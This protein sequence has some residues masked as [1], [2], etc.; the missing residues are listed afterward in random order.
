V[1][2]AI[3]LVIECLV[4]LGRVEH[5]DAFHVWQPLFIFRTP[6][7]RILAIRTPYGSMAIGQIIDHPGARLPAGAR[8]WT[9]SP[10]SGRQSQDVV[11]GR[12]RPT[13]DA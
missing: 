10:C 5:G 7:V 6:G 12:R 9:V 2:L 11:A 13:P 1:P 4:V 8:E 3:E